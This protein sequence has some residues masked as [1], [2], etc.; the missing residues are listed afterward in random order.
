MEWRSAR[1]L[2]ICRNS[3]RVT[4]SQSE[5]C[6]LHLSRRF[7]IFLPESLLASTSVE[8]SSFEVLRSWRAIWIG[9][10][11]RRRPWTRTGGFTRV[12]ECKIVEGVINSKSRRRWLRQR[13]RRND[14]CRSSQR[15]D[16]SQRTT[17]RSCRIGRSPSGPHGHLR[18]RRDWHPRWKNWW[19]TSSVRR[20]ERKQLSDGISSAEIRRGCVL[21]W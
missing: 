19:E 11:L 9:Q 8:K 5:F 1:W 3:R 7:S 18:R 4:F 6:Y 2:V 14:D 16:Q 17:G 15:A 13:T 12:W 20:Q 21:D 10:K